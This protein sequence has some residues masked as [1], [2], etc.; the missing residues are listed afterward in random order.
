MNVDQSKCELETVCFNC[1]HFF[2]YPLYEA[3]E[4]GIC[5]NDE[6]FEPYIDD[7]FDDNINSPLANLLEKKKYPGE[8]EACEK[9]DP[10]EI[11]EHDGDL[12]NP[13]VQDLMELKDSGQLNKQSIDKLLHK[14]L[15]KQIDNIDWQSVPI[16]KHVTKLKSKDPIKREEAISNLFGLIAFGNI[17][18]LNALLN[19]FINL[20]PA[21]SI[22]DVR[23]KIELLQ[24]LGH[25]DNN[26]D[27][28]PHLVDELY[29]TPSNNTTRQWISAIFKY[30]RLLPLEQVQKPIEE[31]L[32]DK[33][34]SYRLKNKMK[35]IL[36]Q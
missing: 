2:P 17:N 3:T 10:V 7:I 18:A 29:Q 24:K 8:K 27:L 16:D 6:I 31:M 21:K 26:A 30:L 1:N 4:H 25:T 5:L 34:F 9:F 13:L 35:E 36:Y 11:T 23:H 28:L 33:R 14:T 32:K 19:Y 20:S 15:E 22:A 12:D